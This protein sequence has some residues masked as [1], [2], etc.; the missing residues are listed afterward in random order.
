MQYFVSP[1]DS[2]LKATS[3]YFLLS[4]YAARHTN[5][6]LTLLVVNKDATCTFNTQIALTNF[7]PW[8][9]AT[10]Y[11]YGIPQD[12]AART[13]ATPA[14]QGVAG[15]TN[16]PW[17]NALFTNSFPPYSLTLFTFAPAAA[18]LTP[19]TAG[20]G[21]FVFQ[22]QGQ[23]ATPYVIQTTTN[24]L[25]WTA[26]STNTLTGSTINITNAIVSNQSPRF[27]RA[28]WQP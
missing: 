22:L 21:H 14:A 28:V 15:P 19:V 24:L 5:G 25:A 10:V 23:P 12:E 20:D 3:D 11:S 8:G 1:G 18:R 6:A 16:Y 4:A 9:T 26:V 27:W 2:V 17:A 7:V 13:N